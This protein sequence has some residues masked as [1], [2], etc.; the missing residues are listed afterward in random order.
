MSSR[1]ALRFKAGRATVDKFKN[2]L[3]QKLGAEIGRAIPVLP[4]LSK[5]ASP[6]I[7]P[8]LGKHIAFIYFVI[9]KLFEVNTLRLSSLGRLAERSKR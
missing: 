2:K 5:V 8:R 1:N 7:L 6:A 4:R 9:L 3:L